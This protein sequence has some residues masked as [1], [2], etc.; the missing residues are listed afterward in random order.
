MDLRQLSY[1]VT[2][3]EEG[4]ITGAAR[5]LHISQPPLSH[6]MHLLEKELDAVLFI[7]GARQIKLT[8]PGIALYRYAMEMLELE[9]VAKDEITSLT[10]GARGSIR[11]GLVS[12]SASPGLYRS[13]AR[14]HKTFPDVSFKVYE[15]NT[16]ELLDML[17][18]GKIEVAILRTPFSGDGLDIS[19]IQHDHMVA[20]GTSEFFNTE[21]SLT[22]RDLTHHPL[23]PVSYT[24]LTLPTKA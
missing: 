14:F 19:P 16:F 1:F 22:V 24:H 2:I 20:A 21:S 12:S 17:E 6:Q 13:L 3:V 10:S 5:K 11:L 4:T 18:K 8:E 15:G 7:R 23:I 9:Q